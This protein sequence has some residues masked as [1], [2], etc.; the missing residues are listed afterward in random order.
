MGK[1]SAEDYLD[2]LLNSVNDEKVKKEKF[3]EL[4]FYLKIEEP[5][6]YNLP[7][8]Q[9]LIVEKNKSYFQTGTKTICYNGISMPFI[10][11]SRKDG[12]KIQRKRTNKETKE[13][14]YYTQKVND[15]LT[16]KKITY[17]NRIKT[18]LITNTSDEVIYI[19]GL[20]IS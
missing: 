2:K 16:N 4:E 17:L 18:L 11:R 3:K 5:G 14:T 9:I 12:D 1:K 13:V 19:L 15:V 20:I 8:N 10:V 7:N 6:R